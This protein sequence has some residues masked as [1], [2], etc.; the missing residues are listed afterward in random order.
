MNTI[1]LQL[2]N[3]I[4]RKLIEMAKHDGVSLNQFIAVAAAEKLSAME[5]VEYLRK[6]AK[7]SSEQAFENA[8]SEIPDVEPEEYDR[9]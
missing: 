3:S 4:Y 2:P 8:L 6:R 5:T 7:R 1:S 9:L